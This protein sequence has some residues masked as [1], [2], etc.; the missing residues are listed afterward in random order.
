MAALCPFCGSQD[1]SVELGDVRHCLSCNRYHTIDGEFDPST[2]PPEPEDTSGGSMTETIP[3]EEEPFPAEP[4]PEETP[5][6]ASQ[7]EGEA[8]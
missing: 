4:T 1:V 2:G 7:P 3:T 5:D 8:G 6:G